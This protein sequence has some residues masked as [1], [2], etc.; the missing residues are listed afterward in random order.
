MAKRLE[1]IG[2]RDEGFAIEVRLTQWRVAR[3][4]AKHEH[5]ESIYDGSMTEAEAREV[6]AAA[7]SIM[8][9]RGKVP[10]LAERTPESQK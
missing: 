3:G 6:L 9:K 2:Y 5:I 4:K 8:C 10:A 1:H 7:K